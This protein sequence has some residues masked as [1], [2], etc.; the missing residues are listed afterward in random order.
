METGRDL[1]NKAIVYRG[2]L[3]T[4]GGVNSS[5]EKYRIRSNKWEA[6]EGYQDLL[7]DNLDSW[8]C[9]LMYYP[10]NCEV[11]EEEDV[12]STMSKKKYKEFGGM[13]EGMEDYF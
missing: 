13:E 7:R 12:V 1:R 9:A 3:Y 2:E 10:S 5:A 4:I 8:C 11:V 6:V